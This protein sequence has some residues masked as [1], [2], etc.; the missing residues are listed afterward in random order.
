MSESKDIKGSK[1]GKDQDQQPQQQRTKKNL[2]LIRHA[3][4]THNAKPPHEPDDKYF[5]CGLSE[6][7]KQQASKIQGPVDLLLCS[8]LRR[9]LETYAHSSLRVKKFETVEEL[10]EWTT[11]GPSCLYDLENPAV[12]E[13]AHQFRARVRMVVDIIRQKPQTNIAILSHGAT[14]AELTRQLNIPC[15]T[16]WYNAEVKHFPDVIFP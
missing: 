15:T 11:Y 4:S 16:G 14:L 7:G 1:Y 8:P 9:T 6:N 10:R 5:N 12:L 13:D 2:W 3:E